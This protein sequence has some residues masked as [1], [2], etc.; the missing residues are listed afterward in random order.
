MGDR[1]KQG[2]FVKGH[3]VPDDWRAKARA[4]NKGNK[5]A[6]GHSIS[7]ETRALWSRQRS[8]RIP[9]SK[10]K[11]F[12][13]EHREN[14]RK[15]KM[16]NTNRRGTTTSAEGLENMRKAHLGQ[17]GFFRGK[18]HSKETKKKISET[19]KGKAAGNNHWNWKGGI[20]PES[21]LI[22]TSSDYE[23]WRITVFER[24]NYTCQGCGDTKGGNL[25]S[26]HILFF[27]TH[28]DARLLVANGQTLCE[29]CHIKLHQEVK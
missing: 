1:D 7:D 3:P 10:G 22:R 28:P 9:W 12:S 21:R 5:H 18:S 27:S 25:V 19:R 24:D 23:R 20:S 4:A 17:P 16:G 6:L 29:P 2:R 8:G 15:A 11:T 13:K 26:H 14:M